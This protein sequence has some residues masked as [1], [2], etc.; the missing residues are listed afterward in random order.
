[1]KTR[2]IYAALG[3]LALCSMDVRAEE[4]AK[5]GSAAAEKAKTSAPNKDDK[6]QGKKGKKAKAD[7][8]ADSGAAEKKG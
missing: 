1:M 6:V 4:P 7:P 8:K 5:A 3:A 2:L